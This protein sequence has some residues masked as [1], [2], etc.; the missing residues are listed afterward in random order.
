MMI[1]IETGLLRGRQ[2]LHKW[3]LKPE[4]RISLRA[5]GY[6]LAGFFLS[7]A[8]LLHGPLP[9][10]TGWILG[11]SGWT[12]I[13]SG[14]GSCAGYLLF[15][16]SA[17][18]QGVV[19]CAL[20]MAVSLVIRDRRVEQD[21]PLL[22]PALAGLLVS[23]AGVLFQLWLGDTTPVGLYV[24]R[25]ALAIGST[26]LFPRVLRS[27]N[28]VLEWICCGVCML[29]LAQLEPVR[30]LNPGLIAGSV[31]SVAGAFPAAAL[32]GLALDMTGIAP[33]SVTA[34]LCGGYLVRFLPR[35]PRW[36]GAAAPALAGT[37]LM[38]LNGIF[39]PEL[40]PP[41]LIGGVLGVWLPMPARI[42]ARRGE[43][44]VA[45]VRLE[46][47]AGA[48]SQACQMLIEQ[49]EIPVDEDSLVCRAAEQ[50]CEQCPCRNACQDKEK[51]YQLPGL[52]LHKPLLSPR[53]LPVSCRKSGRFL[54][55]LHRAQEQMRS[56]QADR[57]RQRE[58]REA[59]IQQYRFLSGYL[60][61]LSDQL[62]KKAEPAARSYAPRVKVYANRP[63]ADNG[64]RV[65]WFSG[66]G[67]RYY[68]VLCDGMGS[69]MGAVQE[70]AVAQQLLQR[71]LT[72]GFPAEH[73]LESLNSLCALRNRAGAVTVDLAELQLDTGHVRLYKWG[74][75][76]SYVISEVGA[77][78]IGTAG[79]PPGLSMED[80]GEKAY[81]LSLRRGETLV[82]VSDGVG[83]EA[84]LHCLMNMGGSTPGELARSLLTCIRYGGED[85]AT[86]VLIHLD[87][88]FAATS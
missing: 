11:C 29:A 28:P 87:P 16:G 18:W 42:P 60:R 81:R 38:S 31:L 54:A 44:G 76:P 50:A 67:S 56:I 1:P 15:W 37:L 4:V 36:M 53:E 88:G 26:W 51:L 64:D 71:L 24:L 77:E 72:A 25:V 39:A 6:S 14:V 73:A 83:E 49:R 5:A 3:L 46:M 19:W 34:I 33:V 45:Q 2:T 65:V 8:A 57:L 85:D 43:T 20:A 62:A 9:L 48:L 7:A 12:A 78:K 55:Q 66:V 40:L 21:V 59:V 63:E 22:M 10:A 13:L 30:W 86:V 84:A 47:V 70:A 52:L 69:G 23:S 35:Y 75:M 41:L 58:Y 27:R 17:G 61:T 74:A 79:P 32:S 68:V 80:G 82:L